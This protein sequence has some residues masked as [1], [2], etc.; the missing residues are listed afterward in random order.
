[1]NTR[2]YALHAISPLHAGTGQGQDLIDLPIARE[3][4]TEHPILP[5]SSVKGVLRAAAIDSGWSDDGGS[6]T[7]ALF[8]P[9]TSQAHQH[10]S[11]ISVSDARLL[12][13]P[14]QSDRGTF[15]WLTCPFVLA[16]LRRD[17]PGNALPK[18]APKPLGDSKCLITS[19]SILADGKNKVNKVTVG[20]LSM[21]VYPEDTI[22]DKWAEALANV[23]FA[24]DTLRPWM[25]LFVKRFCIV[26]DD[27]FTW[28]AS[29]NT[30]LR[31]RIRLD[32]EK[33]TVEKG[34]LW[35]EETLP[36]ES[37]LL[38]MIHYSKNNRITAKDTWAKLAKLCDGT[39]QMGGN[40]SVGNG[41]VRMVLHGGAK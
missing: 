19:A 2:I 11:A 16:R 35:Y 27:T 38:G 14:V 12:A 29:N 18:I 39:L 41:I 21:D 13:L 8:G 23:V 31:A 30:E 40:A 3:R 10:G 33:G 24:G 36:S 9:D 37:I 34:G 32:S 4:A 15:A 22:T 28:L 25:D 7:W 20:G 17:L 26:D 5:G 6:T 1:M